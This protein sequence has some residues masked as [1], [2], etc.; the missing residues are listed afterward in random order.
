MRHSTTKTFARTES[1]AKQTAEN[2]TNGGKDQKHVSILQA[3]INRLILASSI[4]ND[5]SSQR[6]KDQDAERLFP[7][8][9]DT[10]RTDT[11]QTHLRAECTHMKLAPHW[12]QVINSFQSHLNHDTR[13]DVL[14][15]K[16][17]TFRPTDRVQP[18][19]N[20]QVD[21]QFDRLKWSAMNAWM[22][23]SNTK[24]RH[25][26]QN[27]RCQIHAIA[28]HLTH[29]WPSLRIA[30]KSATPCNINNKKKATDNLGT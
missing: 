14:A 16:T 17:L 24:S 19:T 6:L 30:K 18:F 8:K 22:I 20:S 10:S 28:N 29:W 11:R 15:L 27:K 1:A 12:K 9:G 25:E 21:W 7:T 26:R 2:H 23:I 4:S 5:A 13:N 3:T